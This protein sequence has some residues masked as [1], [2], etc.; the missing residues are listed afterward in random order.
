MPWSTG[1]L[2]FLLRHKLFLFFI[3]MHYSTNQARLVEHGTF[4]GYDL[5]HSVHWLLLC[6]RD[7]LGPW[8]LPA[9]AVAGGPP[10]R[11]NEITNKLGSAGWYSLHIF[12]FPC[13]SKEL[14]SG[15]NSPRSPITLLPSWFWNA[16]VDLFIANRLTFLV[17]NSLFFFFTN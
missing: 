10:G 9:Q 7:H 13:S 5:V 1:K 3:H 4:P 17:T 12:A 8:G 15:E 14:P 6:I 16:S 11:V 2:I